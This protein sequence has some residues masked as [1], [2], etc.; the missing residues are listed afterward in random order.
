MKELSPKCVAENGDS[1]RV[2]SLIGS[3]EIPA[4][5]RSHA[6]HLEE[7]GAHTLA[8]EPLWFITARYGRLPWLKDRRG[9]KGVAALRE[10]EVGAKGNFRSTALPGVP[11]HENA[12][13]MRIGQRLEKNRIDGTE[14]CCT[15]ADAKAK[16]DNTDCGE[17]RVAAQLT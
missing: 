3:A 10:L 9:F 8:F 12:T 16:G 1:C 7:S 15:G 2:R 4:E 14:D 13:G 11:E 5:Q 6:E 17:A